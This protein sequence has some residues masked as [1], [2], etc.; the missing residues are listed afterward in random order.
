[1]NLAKELEQEVIKDLINE[2][3]SKVGKDEARKFLETILNYVN[4]DAVYF[5]FKDNKNRL[6]FVTTTLSN[7]DVIDINKA[8][9]TDLQ[10]YINTIIEAIK[11]PETTAKLNNIK[12]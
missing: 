1:M 8:H 11:Q 7:I 9:K 10:G 2:V 5:V 12:E 3:I 4:S 6:S